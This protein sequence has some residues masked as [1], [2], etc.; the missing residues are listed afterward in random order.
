MNNL[1]PLVVPSQ[2]SIVAFLAIIVSI[3]IAWLWALR[4]AWPNKTVVVTGWGLAALAGV[5]AL[6]AWLAVSGVFARTVGTPRILA[7]LVVCNLVAV[8]LAVSSVGKRFVEALP[9][10][11]LIGVHGFRLPLELVLHDWHEQ[12]MLPIQMTYSGD[13]WDIVTGASALMLAPILP[14]VDARAQWRLSAAFTVLGLG[15]LVRVMSIAARSLPWPL[16][17]Y[18]NDPPVLLPFHAPYTWI[19]PMCVA[20]A[21]F[22]HLVAVRW[23]WARRRVVSGDAWAT[24]V[25][26]V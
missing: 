17:T 6:T 12:G 19:L 23:L 20:G 8:G 16:R 2:G 25:R 10:G 21:L 5:L 15:L 1:P 24:T 11:A 14:R 4:R 7:Y 22:G 18:L 26:L 13:N 9:L 3:C